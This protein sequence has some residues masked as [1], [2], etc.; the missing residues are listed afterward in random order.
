MSA[1]ANRLEELN[2]L[3]MI[4]NKGLNGDQINLLIKDLFEEGCPVKLRALSEEEYRQIPILMQV[5]YIMKRIAEA[6]EIKLTQKG[7]LPVKMV[8]DIYNQRY[9]PDEYIESGITK[10]YKETDSDFIHLSAILLRLAGLTKKRYGKLSLTAKGVKIADNKETLLKL[11]LDTF[12]NKF[13]W[14]YFDAYNNKYAGI[15]ASSYSLFLL[16]TF[17]DETRETHFY[18][19]KYFEVF[20]ELQL[21]PSPATY[22]EG[23]RMDYSSYVLRTFTVFMKNFGLVELFKGK[24][25][26]YIES[27][28]SVRKTAVF[29]RLFQFDL[30]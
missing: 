30:P 3:S 14:A 6:G 4:G 28:H 19:K 10:L 29:G 21:V 24:R 15:V 17:G 26:Y 2:K 5:D 25:D 11:L 20:P 23:H 7:F 1:L 16:H 13:N 27:D 8:A 9:L 12:V 18:A 22:N